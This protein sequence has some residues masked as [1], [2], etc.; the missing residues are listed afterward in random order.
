MQ[1]SQARALTLR[2]VVNAAST[3][4]RTR[5]VH[6]LL[7]IYSVTIFTLE[8]YSLSLHSAD[9]RTQKRRL[10]QLKS[11]VRWNNVGQEMKSETLYV[12]GSPWTCVLVSLHT[13]YERATCSLSLVKTDMNLIEIKLKKKQKRTR[14]WRDDS[15]KT[16]CLTLVLF[17]S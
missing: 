5:C 16:H 15:N 7:R 13:N 1:F 3:R 14:H 11:S 12:R 2:S 6:H 4:N 9:T 8:K 10:C 17:I